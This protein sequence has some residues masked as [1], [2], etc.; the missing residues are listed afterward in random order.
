MKYQAYLAALPVWNITLEDERASNFRVMKNVWEP[1]LDKRCMHQALGVLD[2][3]C[4]NA[5][6]PVGYN[7]R[8]FNGKNSKNKWIH[9]PIRLHR[10]IEMHTDIT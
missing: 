6:P 2:C 8:V 1:P 3:G 9:I 5:I 10:L 4:P 7:V